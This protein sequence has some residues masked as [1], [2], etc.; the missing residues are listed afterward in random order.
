MKFDVV[1][2]G[3]G[4]AGAYCAR[5]LSKIWGSAAGQR[6]AL[7]AEQNVLV[8]QPML[9][10]VAGAALSP[11]SVVNPLREFCGHTHVLQGRI[12][13]IH[14]D[15][16][17]LVL[18]AGVYTSNISIEFEHLVV[19]L[20][21]IV[22]LSR[23]PGMPEHG[24]ILKTVGDALKLR[25][26]LIYRLEEANLAEDPEVIR[27]LLTF[28]VVGGGYSGVETAGQILDLV[29]D[30]KCLYQNLREREHRIFLVHSGPFLLPD[31]G[32][33]L[34][35]YAEEQLRSRGLNILLNSRVTAMT[36]TKAVLEGGNCIETCTVVSTVGNAPHPLVVSLSQQHSLATAK[37]R[38]VTEPNQQVPGFPQVWVAGDCAA[39]PLPDQSICPPTAQFALRQGTQL[40]K[41]LNRFF[42]GEQ[43]RP[44]RF[45]NLGQMASIGH[46]T[47]VADVFGFQFSGFL[48]WWF[49]RTVY[50]AKLPG[51]ERK[52]QVV[53]SWTLDLFFRRD[54]SLILPDQSRPLPDAHLE[55]GD[56]L[57]HPGDP[58][59]SIYLVKAGTM[60]IRDG[61]R[62]VRLLKAGDLVAEPSWSTDV[63]W[64]FCAVA[65]SPTTVVAL[66]ARVRETLSQFTPA[67]RRFF[68][69][70]PEDDPMA[71]NQKTPESPSPNRKK[72][73]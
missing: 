40:A 23:V 7:I 48:A 37:G 32:E 19:A 33:P 26:T 27:R 44:F 17:R 58:A 21:G 3:G 18:D 54:I 61:S 6:A 41:N 13:S 38:L 51:W 72:A 63:G 20:G 65:T 29:A 59:E 10:E 60:E 4:F 50:M 57:F 71:G 49:W 16:H 70:L 30:V 43:L 31:I 39:V 14:L 24:L 11:L 15:E 67:F 55:I 52:I 56:F 35:R 66:N 22:D 46:Q 2:A 8:F 34:G 36:A 68:E 69:S 64:R 45:T 1:I 47:A 73:P 53:A 28:V 9:A 12:R 42:V 62:L 5:T 25:R